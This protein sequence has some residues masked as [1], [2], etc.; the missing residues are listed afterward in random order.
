MVSTLAARV[1]TPAVKD[2]GTPASNKPIRVGPLTIS[3]FAILPRISVSGTHS[4]RSASVRSAGGPTY[5][6][7]SAW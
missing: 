5:S 7:L 4:I 6:A 3:P 1:G 2:D